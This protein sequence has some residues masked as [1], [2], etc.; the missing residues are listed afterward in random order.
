MRPESDESITAELWVML[1]RASRAVAAYAE[2]SVETYNICMS[3]FMVLT[4][5]RLSLIRALGH[6]E[7]WLRELQAREPAIASQ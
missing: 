6:M 5:A 7:D 1:A 3:D 4:K 2:Y